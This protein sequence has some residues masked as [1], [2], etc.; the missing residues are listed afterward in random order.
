MTGLSTQFPAKTVIASESDPVALQKLKLVDSSIDQINTEIA[1]LQKSAIAKFNDARGAFVATKPT[2]PTDP[3]L[4]LVVPTLDTLETDL[5]ALDLTKSSTDSINGLTSAVKAL[6]SSLK[7]IPNPVTQASVDNVVAK[8]T[9]VNTAIALT[10]TSLSE[11]EG[12]KKLEEN[13]A[14][15]DKSKA[16]QADLDKINAALK[17]ANDAIDALKKAPGGTTDLTAV[18]AAIAKADAE[19]VALR[20]KT[21][22]QAA[23]LQKATQS[24][25][26][27]SLILL[28]GG[29]GTGG[30]ASS[31]ELKAIQ[32]KLTALDTAKAEKTALD[33]LDASVTALNKAL[34]DGATDKE[35]ED[36]IKK[37]DGAIADIESS[38]KPLIGRTVYTTATV[39]NAVI[40]DEV[41]IEGEGDIQ[42]PTAPKDG[43][44]VRLF[45]RLGKI[46][47]GK[48]NLLL[49]TDDRWLKRDGTFDTTPG[50]FDQDDQL[51]RGWTRIKYSAPT[52]SW[53]GYVVY[54]TPVAASGGKGDRTATTTLP[55]LTS[56][57]WTAIPALS[58]DNAGKTV[59]DYR[60]LSDTG[61]DITNALDARRTASG[62]ELR[63]LV[64]LTNI[65]ITLEIES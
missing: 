58:G 62:W 21:D 44:E 2:V 19:I 9:A 15:I 32:D 61:D 57:T 60:V 22:E 28:K 59:V 12:I 43:A 14:A 37:V 36:A 50:E 52:K 5:A 6:D 46:K 64:D 17:L 18:N 3:L 23:A 40:G 35:L 4:A 29:T 8:V 20:T 33:T 48:N 1:E 56:N 24:I 34:A 7:A 63:S 11:V 51:R 47:I 27:L 45:D 65:Q 38:L 53:S 49:G 30:G 26:D 25:T 42:L 31:T 16:S 54:G 39:L 10:K 41:H 13:L 55:S